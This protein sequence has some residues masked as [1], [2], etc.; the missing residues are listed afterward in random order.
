MKKTFL[1]VLFFPTFLVAQTSKKD[2][3]WLP[4]KP[5]LGQWKGIGGGEPG[6]GVYD[7]SYNLILN[8]NFIEIK[9][10]STYPPSD[11]NPNGEIHE[12]IGYFSY[13]KGIKNFKLRQFHMEGFVNEFSLDSISADK[14]TLVFVSTAI[15]NIPKGY[16]AKETYHLISE[17]EIEE[18]FEIA[19]PN[20][21]FEVYSKVKLQK[22]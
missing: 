8:K 22:Q 21:G 6:T 15:E 17:T 18:V 7:R 12:D 5:F 14:K 1:I 20:K 16:R 3:I 10:K 13:D 19:E 9:N 4:L 2:S 11:K